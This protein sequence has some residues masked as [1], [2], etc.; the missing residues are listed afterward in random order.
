V[1]PPRHVSRQNELELD[2]ESG[3]RRSNDY[4]NELRAK[5]GARRS[6]SEGQ[7]ARSVT[8]V[9]AALLRHWRDPV[10]GRR[11]FFCQIEAVETMIWLTEVAPRSEWQR[12]RDWNRDANP[13][14]LR[15]ALKLATGAGKT[16]VMGMLIAW[17]TLNRA[18]MTGSSRFT[19]PFLVITPGITIKDR[20]R[21]LLPSDR[22][23]I[24]MALDLVPPAMRDNLQRARVVITN[25]HAFRKRETMEAPKLV[26]EVLGG[27]EGPVV[28]LESDGLMIRR[29]CESLMGRKPIMVSSDEAHHCDRERESARASG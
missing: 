13:E 12:L 25:Y 18:R 26:K 21:V 28:T 4:V 16:T 7:Q 29:I 11:L 2:A 19:D 9:T 5:V 23:N 24:Y 15:V 6:L 17:Q 3:A 1:P 8:P 22:T 14:L 10:R 20:L 27:R